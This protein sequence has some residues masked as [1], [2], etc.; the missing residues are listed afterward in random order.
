LVPAQGK[1]L[2]DNASVGGVSIV[3]MP[4]P[5]SDSNRFATAV[6]NNDGSFVLDTIG[7]KG[8]LPGPY[9]VIL[10]KTTIIPKVTPEEEIKL[11]AAGKSVPEPDVVYHIPWKYEDAQKSGIS[12]EIDS[13]GKKDI[14][15]DN[16]PPPLRDGNR[17]VFRC[18]LKIIF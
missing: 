5:G 11:L 1:V 16:T 13:K 6:S 3:F 18:S 12:I 7:N 14:L 2:F 8:A 15:P 17:E 9:N 10:S 4:S